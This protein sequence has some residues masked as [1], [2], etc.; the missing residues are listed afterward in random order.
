MTVILYS[1]RRLNLFSNL[2]KKMY[3]SHDVV[4]FNDGYHL[5]HEIPLF[6]ERTRKTEY[7]FLTALTLRRP[8]TRKKFRTNEKLKW[9]HQQ[10][11][12]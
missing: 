3:R 12:Y 11:R 9:S 6:G 10:G 2:I 7:N 1:R 5:P 8:K 4:G